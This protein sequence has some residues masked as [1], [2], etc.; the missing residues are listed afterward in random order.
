MMCLHFYHDIA[1]SLLSQECHVCDTV[2]N[3]YVCVFLE[4]HNKMNAIKST[5]SLSSV[6]TTLALF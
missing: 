2:C 1:L 5:N 4:V 3:N 6:Y